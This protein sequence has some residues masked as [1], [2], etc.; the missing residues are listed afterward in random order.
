M[1]GWHRFFFYSGSVRLR[2]PAVRVREDTASSADKPPADGPG[3]SGT[4]AGGA[5]GAGPSERSVRDEVEQKPRPPLA[6]PP[7]VTSALLALQRAS[8]RAATR[9]AAVGAP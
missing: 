3:T 5:D 1:N 8:P 7:A 4:V 9:G 6:I 2:L